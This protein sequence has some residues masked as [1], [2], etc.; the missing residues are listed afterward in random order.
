MYICCEDRLCGAGIAPLWGVSR[1]GFAQRLLPFLLADQSTS[2]AGGGICVPLTLAPI[3]RTRKYL[4]RGGSGL[5]QEYS[6]ANGGAMVGAIPRIIRPS[7]PLPS[8]GRITR[9]RRLNPVWFI[10]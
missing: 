8:R 3:V 6:I 4:G 10:R 2:D 7:V 1:A 9:F 5:R